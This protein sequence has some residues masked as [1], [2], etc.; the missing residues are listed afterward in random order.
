MSDERSCLCGQHLHSSNTLVILRQEK[1][2]S[3]TNQ[4]FTRHTAIPTWLFSKSNQTAMNSCPSFA[5]LLFMHW[6]P[7]D[8]LSKLGPSIFGLQL[9]HR[10]ASQHQAKLAVC[11]IPWPMC[12]TQSAKT[13]ARALWRIV[14]LWS[15]MLPLN[16]VRDTTPPTPREL[17]T[18]CVCSLASTQ[19]WMST[20][21]C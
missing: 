14:K 20:S 7:A 6:Q 10:T 9:S 5:P 13:A 16:Y 1:Q 18:A 21:V 2:H 4:S 17:N 3:I 19:G 12:L 15:K 8:L 11:C